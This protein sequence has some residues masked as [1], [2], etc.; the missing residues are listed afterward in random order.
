MCS[1][2]ALWS[3]DPGVGGVLIN[4]VRV[5]G[6]PVVD[7]GEPLV[8]VSVSCVDHQRVRNDGPSK[9]KVRA[10]VARRLEIADSFL[11]PVSLVVV[12]GHRAT[13]VQER[14]WNH[15][16]AEV[17]LAH[18]DWSPE[19]VTAETARFVAPPDGHPPHST[20]GAVDV[21]LTAGGGAEIDMGSALN[22]P[23]PKMAMDAEVGAEAR[24][25]RDRLS[26]AMSEAGFVDY[27]YEWWHFSYGDQYWAWRT[28]APAALYGRV[29]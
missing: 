22:D 25:W 12:E 6:V 1:M 16:Y 2:D 18:P 4:D 10:D 26:G 20:G 28:Q 14:F 24:V 3:P 9:F 5:T 13:T 17:R 21:I 23:G 11:G 8:A 7:V 29:G 27:P 15:R 19:E